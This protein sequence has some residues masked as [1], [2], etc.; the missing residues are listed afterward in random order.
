MV[1]TLGFTSSFGFLP[2]KQ[3]GVLVLTN[4][5]A[6]NG[7][8]ES[9][10]ARV[11]ELLFEQTS[12]VQANLDFGYEQEKKGLAEVQADQVELDIETVTP[13]VGTYTN[14]A[15]G[16]VTISL[17]GD[18]L[19]MDAGEFKSAL[20]AYTLDDKIVYAPSDPPLASGADGGF[21]F[22]LEGDAP[23]I[24]LVAPPDV[25]TFVKK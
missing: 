17:E 13:F 14:A 21:E 5:Q 20:L 4:A 25:Y 10:G 23:I 15:L 7:F 6:S 8:N 16:D 24:E 12:E 18:T 3:L 1:A 2:E 11:F 22:K 9:V 19:M